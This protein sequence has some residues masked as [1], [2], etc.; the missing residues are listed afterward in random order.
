MPEYDDDGNEIPE[1][2]SSVIKELRKKAERAD[3]ADAETKTLRT[4]NALLKAG[5]GDLSDRQRKAILATHEGELTAE[6]LKETATDLGF[7]SPTAS[8]EESPAVSEEEQQGHE[9]VSAATTA[10]PASEAHKQTL[11][12]EINAAPDEAAVIAILAREKMLAGQSD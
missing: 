1:E 7:T 12:D 5:L 4:E 8:T 3:Q 11:T 9:R 6:A 10:A 2:E